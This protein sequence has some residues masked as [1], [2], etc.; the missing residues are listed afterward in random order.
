MSKSF[1]RASTSSAASPLIIV[2]KPGSTPRVCVDCR[3]LNDITVKDR[4]LLPRIEESLNQILG[5]KYFT[6]I[7]LCCYFNQI[8][9][10]EGDEWK[11]AFCSCYGLFEFLVIPFGLTNAP[12]TVQRFMNDT[13]RVFL[14]QFC[15]VYLDDILIYSKTKREHR[16]HVHKILAKLKE[17]GLYTNTEKCEFNVEKTTFLGFIISADGIEMDP[18]KIRGILDWEI[19]KSVKDVLYFLGFANFYRRFIKKYSKLCQP[20]FNLLRKP[21][22]Q[23]NTKLNTKNTTPFI[24]SPECEDVFGQL[25]TAFTSAPILHHCNPELETTLNCNT[26]DYVVSSILAQKHLH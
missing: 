5:A 4:H 23:E 22:N 26:S 3:A 21:E 18:A 13:L 11:T 7:D 19:L 10:Q 14:D 25:K 16:E 15:V 2:R 6:K 17:A 12:A 8:R 24:W 9:I 20:R 1:I